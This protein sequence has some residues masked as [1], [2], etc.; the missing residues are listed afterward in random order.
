MCINSDAIIVVDQN[1]VAIKKYQANI[2]RLTHSCSCKKNEQRTKHDSEAH[3]SN[4]SNCV[5]RNARCNR[6]SRR[7]RLNHGAI[8]GIAVNLNNVD[9]RRKRKLRQQNEKIKA[10]L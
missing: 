10:I 5:H 4:S 7:L 2:N 6:V 8:Y 9:L 3:Y 1:A